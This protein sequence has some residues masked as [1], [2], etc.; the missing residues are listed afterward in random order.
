M[1][2]DPDAALRNAPGSHLRG[3]GATGIAA[4]K[5]RDRLP[6]AERARFLADNDGFVLTDTAG[7]R[8][9]L[10]LGAEGDEL[11]LLAD[12]GA[13]ADTGASGTGG[14]RDGDRGPLR[15]AADTAALPGRGRAP[16]PA[17]RRAFRGD[18]AHRPALASGEAVVLP[19][20][21][22]S[23]SG[24]S[25]PGRAE[26]VVRLRANG[27]L[28]A[29]GGGDG[30]VPGFWRWSG[31]E[32]V[33]MLEGRAA[34]AASPARV[35]PGACLPTGRAGGAMRTPAHRAALLPA[36]VL[37]AVLT[38]GA[39]TARAGD[40]VV[41][42]LPGADAGEATESAPSTPLAEP[43]TDATP[44]EAG[45]ES[46]AS[47]SRLLRALAEALKAP[48]R[49]DDV[50]S[51][52]AP[53]VGPRV[54]AAEG[55][56]RALLRRLLAGAVDGADALTALAIEREAL[57]LC[58]ERQEIVAG[59]FETEARL[60]ELRAPIEA[61]VPA[62]VVAEAAAPGLPRSFRRKPRRS[63]RSA[64][65]SPGRPRRRRKRSRRRPPMAG[66]RSSA[67]PARCAPGSPTARPSGSCARAIPCPT[68]ARSPPSKAGRRGCAWLCR[69]GT[70][71]PGQGDAAALQGAAGRRSV[72]PL[73]DW[74]GQW[75][76]R[77]GVAAESAA[78]PLG[79]DRGSPARVSPARVSAPDP[80]LP[81]RAPGMDARFRRLCAVFAD[82]RCLIAEGYEPDDRLRLDLVALRQAGTIPAVLSEESV[83]LEEIAALWRAG[84][85]VGAG[86]DGG[87]AA[88][89]IERLLAD[90][91]RARASDVVFEN[92]R[93]ACKVFCIVNDRKL[94]LCAPLTAEEGRRVM[95]F[96]FHC[97]DEGSSQTSYRRASFQ[98]F[99]IR[100][101]G[102]V[103]LP[104]ASRRS[105][106]SAARTTRTPTTSSPPLL[107]RPGWMRT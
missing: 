38:A 107:P 102:S 30:T 91:A 31:G 74:L 11:W 12:D 1:A 103:P 93:D 46:P 106:A 23:V 63:R 54:Y 41:P 9:V 27:T 4:A 87:A 81:I 50:A 55:C 64:R 82:G 59:L 79:L 37:A 13:V 98:G 35:S 8:H 49:W 70:L 95:G 25:V 78:A 34:R 77:L 66:S 105:A 62:P 104:A 97:K 33:V 44:E 48:A 6:A 60:A 84:D 76:G 5:G 68:A 89:R 73:G 3:P 15:A 10:V 7:A 90:A 39:G 19:P 32:L 83:P 20:P 67:W 21:G 71:G 75:L 2:Q 26:T 58:R 56:P 96:L 42:P 65:R 14:G 92:G 85:R 52:A 16:L 100:A 36:M 80:D 101:G 18:A 22:T 88:R 69:A 24:T 43:G 94:P 99:S 61:P 29:D 47:G 17:H 51:G 40:G 53:L 28:T 72:R 57:T 86:G 45:S